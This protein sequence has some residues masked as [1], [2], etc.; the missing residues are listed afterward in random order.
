MSYSFSYPSRFVA[1]VLILGSI[2]TA[3]A[4][5]KKKGGRQK[6][7]VTIE[8]PNLKKSS[9]TLGDAKKNRAELPSALL[10][11]PTRDNPQSNL[12][13]ET[14]SQINYGPL[15][16]LAG[17]GDWR[18]VSTATEFLL[19]M[20]ADLHEGERLRLELLRALAI[21]KQGRVAEALS[22]I[23]FYKKYLDFAQGH[24][25]QIRDIARF[26]EL[27]A[28]VLLVEHDIQEMSATQL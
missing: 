14:L 21:A 26:K 10:M 12:P 8:D 13:A 27:R 25:R 9:P 6:L 22:R 28:H 19:L 2:P 5:V 20:R 4:A 18:G 16:E 24:L 11:E 17:I 1:W 7:Q 3:Y 15:R 23:E